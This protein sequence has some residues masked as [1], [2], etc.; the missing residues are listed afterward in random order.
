MGHPTPRGLP[1]VPAG[2]NPQHP[3]N[4][5]PCHKGE[6]LHS[7]GGARVGGWGHPHHP[8]TTF[9]PWIHGLLPPVHHCTSQGTKLQATVGT[10]GEGLGVKGVGGRGEGAMPYKGFHP[11][12]PIPSPLGLHTPTLVGFSLSLVWTLSPQAPNVVG[13]C[14][15]VPRWP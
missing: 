7:G 12:A 1:L 8:P 11:L 3:P 10:R 5:A 4:F 15:G 14:F 6:T 13:W 2:A 9:P